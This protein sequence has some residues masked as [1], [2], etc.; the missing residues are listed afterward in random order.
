MAVLDGAY[1]TSRWLDAC[2]ARLTI[3]IID[4]SEPAL[5]AAVSVLEQE[6]AY[7]RPI[8]MEG[9]GWGPPAGCELLAFGSRG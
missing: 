7:M 6:R 3:A 2:E 1:A 9:L 8:S 4:R 5:D